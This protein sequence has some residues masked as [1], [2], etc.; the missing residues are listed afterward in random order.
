MKVLPRCQFC[1]KVF[2]DCR[3]AYKL[4]KTLRD[5]EALEWLV[6]HCLIEDN[7]PISIGRG[8]ELLGFT[9]MQ[10]MRD[11]RDEYK[12]LYDGGKR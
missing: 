1:H 5:R 3:C 10:Q 11:W 7:P 2:N 9:D 6:Y 8:K 12:K 4:Y